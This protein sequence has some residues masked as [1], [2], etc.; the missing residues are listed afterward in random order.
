MDDEDGLRRVVKRMLE[1]GGH[2]VLL[3][4]D[5]NEG[6]RQLRQTHVDLIVT[7]IVMPGKEGLET[8]L[9]IRRAWPNLRIIAMSGGFGTSGDYLALAQSFGAHRI[10]AK[11]FTSEQLLAAVRELSPG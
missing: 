4:G 11:P 6:L 1:K 9:E 8:I 7:D 2:E 10:L 5:G 3:A